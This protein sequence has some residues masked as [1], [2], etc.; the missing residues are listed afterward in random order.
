MVPKNLAN[1]SYRSSIL[2]TALRRLYPSTSDRRRYVTATFGV[3]FAHN[4]EGAPDKHGEGRI[5]Y[6]CIYLCARRY[7]CRHC[8][9]SVTIIIA[10]RYAYGCCAHGRDKSTFCPSVA[11]ITVNRHF[12]PS[13]VI[14][15]P[16]VVIRAAAVAVV[17][18]IIIKYIYALRHN[19][20]ARQFRRH[21]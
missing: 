11:G 15:S 9:R 7:Y 3:R 13:I 2:P 17:K 20:C 8:R 1:P 4:H 19:T 6:T 5:I 12:P 16:V 14:L 18:I 10:A 21:C